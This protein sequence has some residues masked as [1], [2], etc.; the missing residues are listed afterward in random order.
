M[1]AGNERTF[2]APDDPRAH[3]HGWD[4]SACS[5]QGSEQVGGPHR[6]LC[7]CGRK[8]PPFLQ[9]WFPPAWFSAHTES[10]T[11]QERRRQ[12][13]RHLRPPSKDTD[14]HRHPLSLAGCSPWSRKES[15]TTEQ[16]DNN[17][18]PSL[19]FW[20]EDKTQRIKGW[21]N[22]QPL[23]KKKNQTS[24]PVAKDRWAG[25]IP[26]PSCPKGDARKKWTLMS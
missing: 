15:D 2:Q 14:V 5:T 3:L 17:L 11:V 6:L 1:S 12:G 21:C 9:V 24:N 10:M 13:L 26:G 18:S 7:L 25:R 22:V 19:S 4:C 20:R 8:E 23:P 16:L